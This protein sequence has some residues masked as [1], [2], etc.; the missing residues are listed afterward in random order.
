MD[1]KSKVALPKGFVTLEEAIELIKS[2][3]RADAKVDTSWLASHRHWIEED[4]NFRIPLLRNATEADIEE[5][6][7]NP[8]LRGR[9]HST[10]PNGSVYVYIERSYHAEMLKEAIKE[11]Y[12]EMAGRALADEESEVRGVSTVAD[13]NETGG[14]VHIRKATPATKVGTDITSGSEITAKEVV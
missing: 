11:H 9:I 14:Q 13:E 7:K 8:Y 10:V 1:N 5:M 3:T 4:H 6:K 12:Q 2:D